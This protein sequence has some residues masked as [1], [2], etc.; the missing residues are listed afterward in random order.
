MFSRG[1]FFNMGY[2]VCLIGQLIQENIHAECSLRFGENFG[3]DIKAYL[4][5][6]SLTAD[7]YRV[8]ICGHVIP[9]CLG[10]Q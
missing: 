8:F 10:S 2:L 3:G 5:I 4:P 6:G 1:P 9:K 7:Q